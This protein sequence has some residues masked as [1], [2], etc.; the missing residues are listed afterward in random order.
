[1]NINIRNEEFEHVRL[2][3][4]P[5]LLTC[6][7]IATDTVP[8]GWHCYDLRGDVRTFVPQ[9]FVNISTVLIHWKIE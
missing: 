1:M 9:K 7:R 3:G 2:F 8:D 4:K 5:A 6:S